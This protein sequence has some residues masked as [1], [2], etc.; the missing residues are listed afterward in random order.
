MGNND[1]TTEQFPVHGNASSP[2]TRRKVA[3][4]GLAIAAAS[5][6]PRG[7]AQ[8]Q[9]ADP[10]LDKLV[11]A[12]KKEGPP[13]LYTGYT[14][15][16]I[17]ALVTAFQKTYGMQI[18]VQR[19]VTGQL[20]ARYAAEQESNS[21]AA[22]VIMQ[23]DQ[24]FAVDAARKGWLMKLS[25]AEVPALKQWPAKSWISDTYA[26]VVLLPWG[27]SYNTKKLTG[28]D[29]PA[30]WQDLLKPQ[31]RGQIL[32][33]DPKATLSL[34]TNMFYLSKEFGDDYLR[35]FAKQQFTLIPSLVPGLQQI[36]AGEKSILVQTIPSADKA[37]VAAGAPIN[38]IVPEK[39]T[40]F[41]HYTGVSAKA[42][43]PNAGKLLLNFMLTREGQETLVR[44]S[45]FSVLGDVPGSLPGKAFE[46]PDWAE[47]AKEKERLYKLLGI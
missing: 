34:L 39:H 14:P 29:A 36:A 41:A 19:L 8:A 13:T 15:V 37:L 4:G 17:N 38:T 32:F 21:V 30:N 9:G 16:Q 18:K 33:T 22:D 26:P 5:I 24:L 44:D 11:E 12:A 47:M 46:P 23:S 35:E 31:Y 10:A 1:R 40:G 45:G 27:F 28:A 7:A 43:N 3:L 6:L 25:A 42:P 20:I 2:V